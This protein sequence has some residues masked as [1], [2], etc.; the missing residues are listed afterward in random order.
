[1]GNETGTTPPGAGEHL[2]VRVTG[3]DELPATYVNII[4]TGFDDFAFHLVFSQL[5]GPVVLS[6]DDAAEV[7][8]RGIVEARAQ[9][10]LIMTPE[11]LERTIE[12]LTQNLERFRA[13]Q[14]S[15]EGGNDG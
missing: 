6:E 10:R 2:R 11:M 4:S 9:A 15:G 1:M 14:A 8:A 13:Q 12:N 7:A 5:F 3:V